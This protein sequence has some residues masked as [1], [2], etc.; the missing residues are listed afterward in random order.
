MTIS[1]YDQIRNLIARYS[2]YADDDDRSQEYRALFARDGV[3][4]EGGVSLPADRLPL[5]RQLYC[6]L[7]KQQPQPFGA[8]HLQMNSA[9]EIEGDTATAVTDLLT[10]QVRPEE[11]WTLGGAGQYVDDLVREEGQW[12]FKR[13][14]VHWYKG[15]SAR[16][17]SDDMAFN[18]TL[19]LMIKNAMSGEST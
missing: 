14:E 8:K 15:T 11:G 9:I 7:K 5:L 6:E 17:K 1:D 3:L 4:V 2:H 10:I 19:A 13:R 12:R 18:Q 16:V